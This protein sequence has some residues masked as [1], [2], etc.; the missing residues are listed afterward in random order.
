MMEYISVITYCKTQQCT[1]YSAYLP[2]QAAGN[3][4]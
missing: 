1:P 3:E 4:L 2:A